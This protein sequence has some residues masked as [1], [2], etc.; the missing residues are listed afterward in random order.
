[1]LATPDN[2]EM[3]MPT[4]LPLAFHKADAPLARDVGPGIATN[5]DLAVIAV[6]T[7]IG[8]ALA[9]GL[10]V[11]LPHTANVEALAFIST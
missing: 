5:R 2:Q 6:V 4:A 1:L 8:L 9:I 10:A 3:D 11:L 7:A